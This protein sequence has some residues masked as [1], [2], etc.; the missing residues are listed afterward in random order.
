MAIDIYP[1]GDHQITPNLGLGLWGTDEVTSDNF[2][3]IDTAFGTVSGSIKVNGSVVNSPNFI[4]SASVTFSVVGSNIS[5]TAA[6]GGT[7]GLPLGS[8]QGNKAGTFGGVPGT[9]LDFV[10]GTVTIA[11]TGSGAF[12]AALSVMGDSIDNDILDLYINGSTSPAAFFDSNGNLTAP[13]VSVREL[14]AS[15]EIFVTGTLVMGTGTNKTTL[16]DYSGSVGTA[17]QLLSSTHVGVLWVNAP[18]GTVTT[19]SAG[20]LS[21]LFT[22]SV[23]T[24]TTTPALSFSLSNAAQNSVF[25]GPSTGGTGAPSYRAL[26]AADI[27]ALAYIAT[28]LMTTL[29]DIIYENATPAPARLA[30]NTT[31]TKEY[32]SQTGNGTISAAPAWAQINYADI[33]GTTPTPPTGTVLW[34][35][36]GN[37]A[38]NLTLANAAFTTTFNQT[39]AVAWLWANTTTGTALTTNASPL[40]EVAANYWTGSASAADVWTIGTS[41]AV[42][43]NGASALVLSHSGSTGSVALRLPTPVTNTPHLIGNNGASLGVVVAPATS[44]GFLI[45]GASTGQNSAMRW[46]AG[47]T[48][49]IAFSGDYD[50]TNKACYLGVGNSASYQSLYLGISNN[51]GAQAKTT[52]TIPSVIVG[53]TT[54]TVGMGAT[55]GTQ[56]GVS[57]GAL[58][59]EN[60]GRGGLLFNPASGTANFIATRIVA[61]INQTGSASGSYTALNIMAVETALLGT[62]NKLIDCYAGTT[63]TTEVFAVDNKGHISSVADMAGQVTITAASTTQSVTFTANYVGTGQPIVVITPT[64][65]PLALGVPVGYWV[66]YSGSAGAW[67]GFTVNIQ[68]ALAGNVTFNY[69]VIQNR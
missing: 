44:I 11:P 6:S 8:I 10:N 19:F 21:P 57:L 48:G 37:A 55:S 47:V 66:T 27:P 31:T 15:A 16:Q 14:T 35:A 49:T 20:A 50:D 69:I 41:L 59:A 28:G 51:V 18:T 67:T 2:I 65:D 68:T 36:L 60:G 38:A 26:V 33:T 52:T 1:G 39:S 53:C 3:L 12:L 25:A 62:S 13:E 63:G 58:A 64:S 29:G 7:P 46:N 30:G 61:T 34:S 40:L 4:N 43:T 17:G 9:V 42:G 22:T 54:S 23:A 45:I 24:A 5:L 32:L 56:T